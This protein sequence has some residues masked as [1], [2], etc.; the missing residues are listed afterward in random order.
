MSVALVVLTSQF[1]VCLWMSTG[2]AYLGRFFPGVNVAAI[3]ALP[4]D[5]GV[6]LEYRA[7]GYVLE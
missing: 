2:W 4:L 7:F 1:K 6:L 3:T 5:F